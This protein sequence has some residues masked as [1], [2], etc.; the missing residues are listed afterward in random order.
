MAEKTQRQKWFEGAATFPAVLKETGAQPLDIRCVVD[1]KSDLIDPETFTQK[2]E[3]PSAA[4]P[5]TYYKGMI[6]CVMNGDAAGT[7]WVLSGSTPWVG[8]AGS[9]MADDYSNWTQVVTEANSGHI[10]DTAHDSLAEGTDST[11]G[12]INSA[13]GNRSHAEGIGTV[14]QN[15]NEHAEGAYNKSNTGNQASEKTIHSIGIGDSNVRKNAVEVMANGDIYVLGVG[16]YDGTNAGAQDV[17]TLQQFLEEN[18][19]LTYAGLS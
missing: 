11:K 8:D 4:N 10:Y 19:L 7:C 18:Q 6:V 1:V 5:S 15:E 14:A 13:S 9:P 2:G 3:I 16:G 12:S 17:K